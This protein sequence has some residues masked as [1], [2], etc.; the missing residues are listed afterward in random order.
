MER[1]TFEV[2]GVEGDVGVP[3]VEGG[4]RG[5]PLLLHLGGDGGDEVAHKVALAGREREQG[6]VVAGGNQEVLR[7]TR[8][9]ERLEA[10]GQGCH[11]LLHGGAALHEVAAE[12]SHHHQR[13]VGAVLNLGE[14]LA[15]G[16]RL[17]LLDAAWGAVLARN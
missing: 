2:V 16:E 15:G 5:V 7:A 17:G 11:G 13:R 3:L 12:E 14:I 8:A 10:H 4:Q 9:D 6:G 1:V